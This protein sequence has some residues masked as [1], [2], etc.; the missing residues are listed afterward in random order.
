MPKVKCSYLGNL[1]C[2]AIYLQSGLLIT[3]ATLDNCGKGKV[4]PQ[5]IY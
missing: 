1:N 3:D 5:L 4:F 2:E